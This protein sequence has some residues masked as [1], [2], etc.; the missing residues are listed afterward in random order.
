MHEY[1]HTHQS[2]GVDKAIAGR[3]RCEFEPMGIA[4]EEMTRR[5]I[6]ADR[7]RS[8]YT[9]NRQK[10]PLLHNTGHDTRLRDRD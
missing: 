8:A 2:R 5:R 3:N 1:G 6:D 10:G 9:G 4:G 7:D